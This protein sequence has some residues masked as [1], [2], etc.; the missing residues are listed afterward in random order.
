MLLDRWTR[1]NFEAFET[2][3]TRYQKSVYEY[4]FLIL[5]NQPLSEEIFLNTF[6]QFFHTRDHSPDRKISHQLLRIAT[7]FLRSHGEKSKR[8]ID[9]STLAQAPAIPLEVRFATLLGYRFRFAVNEISWIMQRQPAWVEDILVRFE[10]SRQTGEREI[11]NFSISNYHATLRSKLE[12]ARSEKPF[13]STHW[14]KISGVVVLISLC[15]WLCYESSRPQG[16]ER[17]E[18]SAKTDETTARPQSP[19]TGSSAFSPGLKQSSVVPLQ[20][21]LLSKA[22][23]CNPPKNYADF[24][25]SFL[26]P[27][28]KVLGIYYEFSEAD[29]SLAGIDFT[30]QETDLACF[31]TLRFSVSGDPAGFPSSLGI[32][33]KYHDKIVAIDTIPIES[34]DWATV[35]IPLRNDSQNYSA[36]DTISFRIKKSTENIPESGK[37]YIADLEFIRNNS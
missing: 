3:F 21:L 20:H 37:I 28:G 16:F 18:K 6:I 11:P 17:P 23:A 31:R 4:I 15:G 12:R 7:S 33:F 24:S 5:E 25:Y 1:G 14:F 27:K 34:T 22:A 29:A 13:F 8:I 36:F 2:V 9:R 26:P 19:L 32:M 35:D 30:I 10:P